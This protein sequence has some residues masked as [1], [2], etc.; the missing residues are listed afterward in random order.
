MQTHNPLII[1]EVRYTF[2]ID[3]SNKVYKQNDQYD[4]ID[5]IETDGFIVSNP[6][7]ACGGY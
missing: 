6:W 4:T 5:D 1:D 7:S 3:I 2:E